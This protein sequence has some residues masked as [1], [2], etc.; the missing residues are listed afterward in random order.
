MAWGSSFTLRPLGLLYFMKDNRYY[1][2]HIIDPRNGKILYV[3]KGTGGRCYVH[4][5]DWTRKLE[6]T[7]QA[8]YSVIT[9]ILD[10]SEY[11]QFD[12]VKI[13]H[14]KL[15]KKES[16][17]YEIREIRKIGYDNL[18][19]RKPGHEPGLDVSNRWDKNRR[20]SQK[21]RM[22]KINKSVIHRKKLSETRKGVKRPEVSGENHG[23][24]KARLQYDSS[25]K[26][27]IKEWK[28]AKEAS[29]A[30]N[31]P[32]NAIGRCCSGNRSTAGGYVWKYKNE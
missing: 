14:L 17:E 23:R 20:L 1:V 31:I 11:T 27:L 8:L 19:N 15:S 10:H 32:S 29:K 21:N 5:S 24:A 12:C 9:D 13:I 26:N 28:T 30:L 18:L 4:F 6:K 7:N 2:Y 3:G 22:I 25:G 16:Y